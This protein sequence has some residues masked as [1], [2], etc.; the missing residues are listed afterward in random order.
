[1]I[2]VITHNVN[3]YYIS[4]TVQTAGAATKSYTIYPIMLVNHFQI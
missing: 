2:I 1:M 3:G 4:H